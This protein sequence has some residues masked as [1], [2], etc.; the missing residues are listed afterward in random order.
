MENDKINIKRKIGTTFEKWTKR[1]DEGYY[2]RIKSMIIETSDITAK[3]VAE[4]IVIKINT[5]INE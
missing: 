1:I 5:E 2:E 3:Q 4:L